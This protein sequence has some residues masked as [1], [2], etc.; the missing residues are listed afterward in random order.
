[1]F[2]EHSGYTGADIAEYT[3]P[4]SNGLTLDGAGRLTVNEHGN[5][6]VSLLEA[7]G[8]VT[9]LA[10][11]VGG[12]RL[13][14][15][16]DLTYRRDGSLYFTDPPFGLPRFAADPRRE[17]DVAG[18]YRVKDGVTE[19]LAADLAG[20]NGIAFSPDETFLY[21]GN[22]DPARKVVMRYPV[23]ADGRLGAGEVFFDM[24]SAPFA[25]AIDG[26]KVDVLGNLYVAG[27]G[28]LWILDAGGR[29][30]GTLR[31]PKPV[32]N[33]A[34][35]GRDGHTLYLTAHDRLYRMDLL[36]RGTPPGN[37]ATISGNGVA[38]VGG[39]GRR[40]EFGVQP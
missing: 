34:W 29:H 24:T 17:L 14:S 19:L 27:P 21:V 6:R 15:P 38:G 28:G 36:T 2:R 4:G 20:P 9:V 30:L 35:G 8:R 1:V 22:W 33:L 40:G 5:R 7:D 13:N 37:S 12:K 23:R 18:I 16:N 25:E 32:H 3:Q 26:I 10:D 11:N 31:L 39:R